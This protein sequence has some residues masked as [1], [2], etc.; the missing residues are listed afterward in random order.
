LAADNPKFSPKF[1]QDMSERPL[2]SRTVFQGKLLHVKS[3]QVRLPNGH[4]STREYILHPGASMIIAL[5]DEQTIVLERQYRYPLNRHFI[6]LPAGK[7]DLGEDPLHT[8]QR[9]LREECG[10]SAGEWRHL[11]TLHPGIGYSNERIELYLARG[12][13]Q[14][15]HKRDDDEFLEVLHVPVAE[16]MTW[17]RDGRITEAKAVTGL[18][19]A[20]KILRGEW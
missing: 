4:E 2:S 19:W 18:L 20:E 10:Y 3:D 1:E 15:G 11:T 16:A 13:T 12:L 8:A 14:L 9:E 5:L 17:I 7:I 6:E